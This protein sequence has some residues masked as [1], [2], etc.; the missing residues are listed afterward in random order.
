MKVWSENVKSDDLQSEEYKNQNLLE[1]DRRFNKIDIKEMTDK[2]ST[3]YIQSL[4][5]SE[6][7]E[8]SVDEILIRQ[9]EDRL[10]NFEIN[11]NLA[12][13]P[14]IDFVQKYSSSNALFY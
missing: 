8:N 12:L 1:K 9:I 14:H 11:N 7:T 6:V 3:E 2:W 4:I 13:N 5:I 10:S